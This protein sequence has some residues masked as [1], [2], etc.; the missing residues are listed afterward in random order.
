ML[1]NVNKQPKLNDVC[2]RNHLSKT[3]DGAY[4]INLNKLESESIGTHYIVLYVNAE[5]VTYFDSFG[6]EYIPK[7]I[8]KFIGN[9]HIIANVYRIQ[10]YNSIIWEYFYIGFIDFMLKGK[11]LLEFKNLSFPDKFKKNDKIILKY[12][13]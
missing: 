9:K 8:K 13:Q 6:V 5:N 2:S 1:I 11:C 10:S 4:R 7:E 12:F 3:K